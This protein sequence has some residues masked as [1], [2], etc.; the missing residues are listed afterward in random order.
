[1]TLPETATAFDAR[2]ACSILCFPGAAAFVAKPRARNPI[3]KAVGTIFDFSSD[4][5]PPR[6]LSAF[7]HVFELFAGR[8]FCKAPAGA[9]LV[10][11]LDGRGLSPA[12]AAAGDWLAPR[13]EGFAA[14]A[15]QKAFIVALCGRRNRA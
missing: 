7:L 9:Q 14:V 5:V 12:F 3:Q 6:R 2:D 8:R 4:M 10:A 11:P 13:V 15:P 1:M